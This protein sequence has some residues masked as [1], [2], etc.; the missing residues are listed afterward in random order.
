MVFWP[1]IP[2]CLHDRAPVFCNS[3]VACRALLGLSLFGLACESA[4]ALHSQQPPAKPPHAAQTSAADSKIE[5]LSDQGDALYQ[6]KKY[7]QAAGFYEQALK[8][9][10]VTYG[11]NDVQVD[12]PLIN[13][14]SAL[15]EPISA[16]TIRSRFLR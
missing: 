8:L 14:A 10:E 2:P 1:S 11:A 5:S 7:A 13:L 16:L 12:P 3:R 9:A 6:K 15:S 4:P